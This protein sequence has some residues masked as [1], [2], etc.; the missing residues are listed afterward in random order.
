MCS[1]IGAG[2]RENGRGCLAG[3]CWRGFCDAH[4]R[5]VCPWHAAEE[6]ED[7]GVLF[8]DGA[9][10]EDI[11]RTGGAY[12]LVDGGGEEVARGVASFDLWGTP[13]QS[14]YVTHLAGC[15]AWRQAV[16]QGRG[17][18]ATTLWAFMDNRVV[19][20]LAQ[21][22]SQPCG[23]ARSSPAILGNWAHL[24]PLHKEAV[25]IFREIRAG[26]CDVTVKWLPRRSCHIQRVD[27]EARRAA[28]RSLEAGRIERSL[29][30]AYA[31]AVTLF[32]SAVPEQRA[33]WRRC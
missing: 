10:R 32:N 26:G 6:A 17:A 16:E 33:V 28:Y 20:E 18:R 8:S 5:L 24:A 3:G 2:H 30:G 29:F 15:Q 11:G 21:E 19:V 13:A 14:E 9:A 22:A 25:K 12:L 4:A 27:Q 31:E 7:Q 1:R 23:G